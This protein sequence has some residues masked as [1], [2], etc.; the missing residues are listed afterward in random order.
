MAWQCRGL[1]GFLGIP[2]NA[3]NPIFRS[4]SQTF[5]VFCYEEV[6]DHA[7]DDRPMPLRELLD[8]TPMELVVIRYVQFTRAYVITAL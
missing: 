3:L 7:S 1:G 4:S 5:D 6:A 8:E 2:Q